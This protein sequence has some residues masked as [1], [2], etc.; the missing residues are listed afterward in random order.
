MFQ[1]QGGVLWARA[2]YLVRSRSAAAE[3]RVLF[4]VEP[5]RMSTEAR[6]HSLTTNI[7]GN[8]ETR[9]SSEV[10]ATSPCSKVVNGSHFEAQTQPESEITN[11]HPPRVEHLILKPNFGPKSK[12]AQ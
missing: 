6:W 1:D 4:R 5:F 11:P 12:F 10:I 2:V 9:N 8:L 7:S 3:T